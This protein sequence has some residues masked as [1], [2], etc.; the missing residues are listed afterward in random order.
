[1]ASYT[2]SYIT[3]AFDQ[4]RKGNAQTFPEEQLEHCRDHPEDYA[5]AST[6][7]E[8]EEADDESEDSD[9]EDDIDS[10]ESESES[11]EDEDSSSSESSESESESESESSSSESEDESVKHRAKPKRRAVVDDVDSEGSLTSSDDESDSDESS[12][13]ESSSSSSSYSSSSESEESSSESESESEAESAWSMSADDESEDDELDEQAKRRKRALKWLKDSDESDSEDERKQANEVRARRLQARG[14]REEAAAK[15]QLAVDSDADEED[16]ESEFKI[17]D[18]E[19]ALVET[20]KTQ[21]GIHDEMEEDDVVAKTREIL[22]QRGRKGVDRQLQLKKM[23]A[24]LEISEK[25]EFDTSARATLL[26]GILSHYVDQRSG[27]FNSLARP[28][29]LQC[30]AYLGR[31][32]SV[33]ASDGSAVI[34]TGGMEKSEDETVRKQQRSS[35]NSAV[36]GF[37]EQLDED[38]YKSLQSAADLSSSQHS[39]GSSTTT[40]AIATAEQYTERLADA[41]KLAALE[42]V[43]LCQFKID[44]NVDEGEAKDSVVSRVALK[45]MDHLYYRA[46]NLNKLVIKKIGENLKD[47]EKL[48]SCNLANSLTE[49]ASAEWERLSQLEEG[50][51]VALVGSLAA[52]VYNFNGPMATSM[53]VIALLRQIF[54]Y[55]NNDR[56]KEARRL[57]TVSNVHE[58]VPP[59]LSGAGADV[60]TQV[61]Y[62]RALAAIG[63]A[64]F[65]AGNV[66]Q[67]H[68][69]LYELCGQN[70][71]RELLAQGYSRVSTMRGEEKTPEQEKAERRRRL[72]YHMHMNLELVETA[73]MICGVLLEVTQMAYHRATGANS[74]L[75]NRVV[76]RSLELMDR[77]TFLG[78]P[79]SGRDSVLFAGKAAL[80]ADVDRAVTLIKSLKIWDQLPATVLPL[81][82]EGM[83]ETCLQVALYRSML[84]HTSVDSQQLSQHYKVDHSTVNGKLLVLCWTIVFFSYDS[85]TDFPRRVPCAVCRGR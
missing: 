12:S 37:I 13:D 11:E 33:V 68:K 20:L 4:V 21:Y 79:E 32:I 17:V 24:L 74:P 48:L 67:A 54:H 80:S 72:P 85:T 36:A 1:M 5:N 34:L 53:K 57:I 18:R 81:I 59:S 16:F 42:F 39:A 50:S 9:V 28:A 49:T 26:G 70:R 44:T 19:E 77:Q 25:N 56:L 51:S 65:R 63:M 78:P 41:Y 35:T 55:A 8:D 31:L 2:T 22:Q 69:Y 84:T 45:L 6:T 43:A 62:N 83:R 3:I 73:H 58:R 60:N 75:V 38:L 61:L 71:C 76:R 82:E 14:A 23:L 10:D 29:W 30:F 27:V 7:F 64:H 47:G 40:G 46:E 52:C 66:A 15:R